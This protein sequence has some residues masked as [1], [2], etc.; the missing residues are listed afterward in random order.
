M[1]LVRVE[2]DRIPPVKTAAYIQNHKMYSISYWNHIASTRLK[3]ENHTMHLTNSLLFTVY[4]MASKLEDSTWS[5][6]QLHVGS[7]VSRALVQG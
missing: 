4:T 6:T 1:I 7:I 2:L 5:R 3:V